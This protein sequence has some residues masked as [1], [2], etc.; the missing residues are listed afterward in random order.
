MSLLA[1]G[2]PYDRRERR[3]FYLHFWEEFMTRV[4]GVRR[5]GAAALDLAYVACGRTDGFWE[6]G[7]K[8]WDV[9]AGA[10]LVQE[11][12]GRVSNMDSSQLDL[13]AGQIVASNGRIHEEIVNVIRST[14]RRLNASVVT[15]VSGWKFQA[16]PDR[17]SVE[18]DVVL[19]HQ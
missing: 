3:R 16:I 5:S 10:L 12:G 4:Q 18:V 2:F 1:T 17:Q 9:G 13:A 15:A 11:A 6:F 7:L 19:S 14:N 8:P